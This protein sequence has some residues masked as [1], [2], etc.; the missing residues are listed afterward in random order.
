MCEHGKTTLQFAL[1]VQIGILV[2]LVVNTTNKVNKFV[3]SI[4]ATTF[5]V[6]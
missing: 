5:H 6:F 3:F 4:E 1:E 2:N